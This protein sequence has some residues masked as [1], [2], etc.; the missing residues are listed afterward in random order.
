MSEADWFYCPVCDRVA[1]GRE[2]H[3]HDPVRR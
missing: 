1:V 2:T 3:E